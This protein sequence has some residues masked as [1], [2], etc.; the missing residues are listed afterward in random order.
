MKKI[1]LLSMLAL[2]LFTN[3]TGL[4]TKTETKKSTAPLNTS[5]KGGIFLTGFYTGMEYDDLIVKNK[6]GKVIYEDDF[7]KVKPEWKGGEEWETVNGVVKM[8]DS[9]NFDS[10]YAIYNSEWEPATIIV[11]GT[12]VEGDEGVCIGFGAKNADTFYQFNV[13]GWAGT[14]TALQKSGADGG[15]MAEAKDKKFNSIPVGKAVEL[16]VELD[17]NNVKCY[18]D[19]QLVISYVAK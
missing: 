16:K 8:L 13:G 9:M 5:L 19:N 7:S 14:K 3:C 15:V 2:A 4:S 12:K 18:M 17:G 6:D 10:R 11:K 1:I